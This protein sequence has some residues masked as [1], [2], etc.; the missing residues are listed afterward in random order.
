MTA[1]ADTSVLVVGLARSGLAA[2][3]ALAAR[4]EEVVGV[5]AGHPAVEAAGFEVEALVELRAPPDARD[6]EYYEAAG[7]EWAKR[8]PAEEIW[9]ARK[10]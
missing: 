1:F 6:H 8:W 10:R 9:K 2:G 4:G 5:D 7:A 3:R